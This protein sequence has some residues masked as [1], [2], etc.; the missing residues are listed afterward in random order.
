MA[1]AAIRAAGCPWA[2]EQLISRN[3]TDVLPA[4]AAL[5]VM[6]V[7]NEAAQSQGLVHRAPDHVGPARPGPTWFEL[8]AARRQRIRWRKPRFI[9]L[10]RDISRTQTV[11]GTADC[12]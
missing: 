12:S 8:S 7:L 3:V 4:L 10:S 5:T 6:D 11:P 9:V 1:N 2:C